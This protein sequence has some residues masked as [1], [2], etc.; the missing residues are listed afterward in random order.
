MS[1]PKIFVINLDR[2][3]DRLQTISQ[4]LGALGLKWQRIVAIDGRDPQLD[5]QVDWKKLHT[6]SQYLPIRRGPI[7][8]Y[9]SHRKVW[10]K[11]VEENLQQALILEDDVSPLAS[12]DPAILNID[13]AKLGLDSLRLDASKIRGRMPW[14]KYFEVPV[15][16]WL[17]QNRNSWGAG[18]YLV[19]QEGARKQLRPDK[20]WFMADD[21]LMFSR[22]YGVK[23]ALLQP[24]MWEHRHE[25]PSD[26]V[27]PD[28][29]WKGTSPW[30]KQISFAITAFNRERE[31]K[32]LRRELS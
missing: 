11:I 12:W 7:G 29:Y 3:P 22:I 27:P 5:A 26:N 24:L 2:R 25:S 13:I 30:R 8:C 9:L 16:K 19:T 20:M 1:A 10:Q 28:N 31:R 18:A 17:A 6:Y 4:T 21:Y 14:S 15:G 32:R 23:T